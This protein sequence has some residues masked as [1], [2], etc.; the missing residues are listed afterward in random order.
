MR[1]RWLILGLGFSVVLNV[2]FGTAFWQCTRTRGLLEPRV[3]T[4]VTAS[5]MAHM[6]CP[7]GCAEERRIREDLSRLLCAERPDRAALSAAMA[8][9]DAVRA[10]ER[11]RL[12]DHWL[13]HFASTTAE[14]REG[15]RRQLHHALCPWRSAE[16]NRAPSDGGNETSAR[17]QE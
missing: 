11:D 10:A 12:L 17:P 1:T 4:A 16:G 15:L 6:S 9:L 2:L 8:R 14:E 5:G 7:A 13:D 3:G